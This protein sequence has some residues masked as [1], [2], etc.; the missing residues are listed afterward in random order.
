[1]NTLTNLKSERNSLIGQ[2]R[3]I[4][5]SNPGK[6]TEADKTKLQKIQ[7]RLDTLAT[8]INRN[9]RVRDIVIDDHISTNKTSFDPNRAM[10]DKFLRAGFSAHEWLKIHNTMSTTTAG[11]GGYSVPIS[12]SREAIFLAFLRSGGNLVDVNAVKCYQNS[13]T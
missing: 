8:E 5:D 13:A 3:Q 4:L 1:M 9:E 7:G 2:S 10:L 6:L 12:V 11:E